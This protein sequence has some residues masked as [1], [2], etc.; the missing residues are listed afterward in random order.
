[1]QSGT[2]RFAGSTGGERRLLG[3]GT[4]YALVAFVGLGLLYFALKVVVASLGVFIPVL[5]MRLGMGSAMGVILAIARSSWKAT[6]ADSRISSVLGLGIMIAIL[7]LV[8]GIAYNFGVQGGEV[9]VVSTISGCYSIVTVVLAGI[10]LRERLRLAQW[11]GVLT[12]VVGV[13]ILGL[14]G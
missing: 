9:S 14:A 5:L 4:E 12:I 7:D 10:F 8:G 3:K 11:G 6:N 2:G 1:M 13:A